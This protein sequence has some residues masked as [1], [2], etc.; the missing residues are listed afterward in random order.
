MDWKTKIITA[1]TIF[2]ARFGNAEAQTETAVKHNPVSSHTQIAHSSTSAKTARFN[3]VEKRQKNNTKND[4]VVILK[5]QNNLSDSLEEQDSTCISDSILSVTRQNS[6]KSAQ[7]LML[8]VI[9]HF[10]GMKS[11]AYWD[12]IGKV[13]TIGIGNTVRPDGTPVQKGDRIRTEEE[14]LDY[15][16]AHIDANMADDMVTFLPLE[17]MSKEEI[18]IIGS[19]LYNCGS[20]ILHKEDNSLSD[21][22]LLAEKY[23]TTRSDSIAK[24]FDASYL[25]YC[26]AKKKLNPTLLERRKNELTLLH[27]IKITLDEPTDST[28]KILNLREGLLGALYGCL[29]INEKIFSRFSANSPYYCPTDSLKV[30]IDKE[31]KKKQTAAQRPKPQRKPPNI[32]LSMYKKRKNSRH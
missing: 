8:Y 13:W 31:L 19:L 1:V 22:A 18:A 15:V 30:A 12:N 5:A 32:N 10:E 23:F 3:K 11:V 17:K 26:H 2:S 28:R 14:A 24:E 29:G 27:N 6:L 7:K 21:F 9:A 4:T 16:Y 25:N 20:G